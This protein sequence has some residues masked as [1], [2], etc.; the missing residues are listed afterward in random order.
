[1]NAKKTTYGSDPERLAAFFRIGTEPSDDSMTPSEARE[2]YLGRKLHGV[3]PLT[4]AQVNDLAMLVGEVRQHLP[5]DGRALGEVLLDKDTDLV[6][7][8]QIKEHG[9]ELS[10]AVDSEIEHDVGLTLYY[11]AIASAIL[12]RDQRI[13]SHSHSALAEAFGRLVRKR[14][15]DP[16]LARH[17]AKARKASEQKAK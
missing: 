15:M 12:F 4:Q 3:L 9:K 6:V 1:M 14:W 11:A 5:L 13:T 17:F 16:K 2:D 10:K 7:L 8:S